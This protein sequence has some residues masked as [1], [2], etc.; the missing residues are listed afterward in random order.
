MHYNS[1]YNNIHILKFNL[2]IFGICRTRRPLVPIKGSNERISEIDKKPR[3][4]CNIVNAIES[5]R[6]HQSNSNSLR[7][8]KETNIL[9]WE[10]IY[11]CRHHKYFSHKK[12]F[13]LGVSRYTYLNLMIIRSH[14]LLVLSRIYNSHKNR[15]HTIFISILW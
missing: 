1:K 9:T 3:N 5:L 6:N 11:F 12:K 15:P 14:C 10:I 8:E 7:V 13:G 2:P 4:G